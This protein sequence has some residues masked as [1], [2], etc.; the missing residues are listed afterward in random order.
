MS[1]A[2]IVRSS[3]DANKRYYE[4][5]HKRDPIR[6]V[7]TFWPDADKRAESVLLKFRDAC[8]KILHADMVEPERTPGTQALTGKLVLHGSPMGKPDVRWEA[9]LALRKYALSALFLAP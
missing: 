8:N 1:L 5:I 3:I 4:K 6:S 7:G 2:A 9:E